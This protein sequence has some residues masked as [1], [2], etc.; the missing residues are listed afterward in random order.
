MANR[1]LGHS[2]YYTQVLRSLATVS[3]LYT[4]YKDGVVHSAVPA[5]TK[6]CIQDLK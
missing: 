2:V 5:L 1:L 4:V 3:C 6:I